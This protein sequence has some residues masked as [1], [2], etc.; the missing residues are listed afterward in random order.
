MAAPG[1]LPF[2]ARAWKALRG[3]SLSALDGVCSSRELPGVLRAEVVNAGKWMLFSN[4]GYKGEADV[5][6]QLTQTHCERLQTFSHF[7][8][9]NLM[10]RIHAQ[11]RFMAED[12]HI[13]CNANRVPKL[14]CMYCSFSEMKSLPCIWVQNVLKYF[15]WCS[16]N[17]CKGLLSSNFHYRFLTRFCILTF[18]YSDFLQLLVFSWI[19]FLNTKKA[20]Y[21]NRNKYEKYGNICGG[22]CTKKL[23]WV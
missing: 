23:K 10:P 14:F 17:D 22:L 3:C 20:F 9:H 6:V 4:W 18:S 19:I 21:E 5:P 1:S 8:Y 7:N 15:C 12:Q 2:T 16:F 13:P 11:M